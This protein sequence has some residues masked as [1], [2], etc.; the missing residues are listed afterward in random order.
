MHKNAY[1]VISLPSLWVLRRANSEIHY[2]SQRLVKCK[3]FCKKH[4]TTEYFFDYHSTKDNLK[5]CLELHF[6]SQY[7][8][9]CTYKNK[10]NVAMRQFIMPSSSLQAMPILNETIE[11]LETFVNDRIVTLYNSA[12]RP[13]TQVKLYRCSCFNTFGLR[14]F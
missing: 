5:V 11:G 1:S 9:T 4:I 7:L 13:C 10:I 3:L 2:H 6:C 8:S 14:L 12:A